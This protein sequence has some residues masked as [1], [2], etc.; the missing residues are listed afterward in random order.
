MARGKGRGTPT[1][2]KTN[3][4]RDYY[5]GLPSDSQ[6]KQTAHRMAAAQSR[7]KWLIRLIVLLAIAGAV[8]LWGADVMRLAK[9][10]A[11]QT[12][13]EVQGVAGGIKEGRDRRAGA[14]FDENP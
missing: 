11:H 6:Y 1:R 10:Q 14:G 5:D 8:R 2:G 4:V 9:L 3:Q 13:N 7:N 12:T